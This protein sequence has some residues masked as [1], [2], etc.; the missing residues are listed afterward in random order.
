MSTTFEATDGQDH[1]RF[2]SHNTLGMAKPL[3]ETT[4]GSGG[5]D[6]TATQKMLSATSGS[7]LTSLLS[8]FPKASIAGLSRQ[9]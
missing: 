9:C 2:G 7:I 5:D 3:A 4:S 8:M 1:D 6:L